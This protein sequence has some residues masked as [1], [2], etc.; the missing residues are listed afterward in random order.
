MNL[1]VS[2]GDGVD[3]LNNVEL[4]LFSDR[5]V[6]FG[7]RVEDIARVAF[8]LWTPGIINSPT[9][10]AKGISFYT[11]DNGYSLDVMCQ[12][13]L[14]FWPE[15]GAA[16]AARLKAAI[17]AV[18]YT[19]QQLV[20]LMAANGGA[21]TLAGRAAAVKAVAQDIA[22]TAQLEAMGVYSQGI[23]ATL[24]FPGESADYFGPM[25]G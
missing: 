19:T 6:G 20:A 21:D 11:N 1:T 9:L 24:G 25:P 3:V 7:P 5:V 10:F 12:V 15:T 13:A 17:P 16:T 8:A 22:T 18:N 23:V 2:G 14:Q 4:L